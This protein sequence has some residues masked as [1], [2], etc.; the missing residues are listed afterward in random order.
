MNGRWLKWCS[1]LLALCMVVNMLPMS[2][3]AAELTTEE[4]IIVPNF[5]EPIQIEPVQS[6]PVLEAEEILERRTEYTKDFQLNNGLYMTVVYPDAVHYETENGWTEI[7]NTLVVRN[8]AYKNTAGQ[9]EVS[10]PQQ[11]TA[12][13]NISITK[14]GYTLSFNMEGQ[15]RS[16][17]LE[18]A[19]TKAVDSNTFSLSAVKTAV[20]TP[21]QVG[22]SK[23]RE[24]AGFEDT[25]LEKLQSRIQ[26]ANVFENTDILYDLDSNKVKESIIIEKYDDALQGYRYN[27]NTGGMIPVLEESGQILLYDAQQ[28]NVVMVM[29]APFL[30][31][32]NNQYNE[33]IQVQLTGTGSQ[34]TL[35]YLLPKQW[36][37]AAD[38][39]WPV[40]LDPIVKA[41]LSVSNIR[42]RTVAEKKSYDYTWG[43]NTCGYDTDTGIMRFYL[44]YNDLPALSASNVIVNAEIHMYKYGSS[45]TT[46]PVSVHKVTDTWES[47]TLTWSNRPAF[48]STVEDYALVDAADWYHWDVTDIARGWYAEENTGMMFKASAEIETGG[49]AS[50]KQFFSSDYGIE[51]SRP[52]LTITYRH[53]SGIE[54]YYTYQTMGAGHAGTA[55]VADATGLLTVAKGIASYASTVNP[56]AVSLVHNA[57]QIAGTRHKIAMD[58]G[59]GFTMDVIESVEKSDTKKE[60]QL[61]EYYVLHD[62]DGTDHY[63]WDPDND[64]KYTDEDGLGLTMTVH[65]ANYVIA[66]DRGNKRSFTNGLLSSH[67]DENENKIIIDW[68][69]SGNQRYFHN[70]YQKN[71]NGS[72]VTLVTLTYLSG[73]NY[74]E[75]LTDAAGRVYTFHYT[76]NKLTAISLDGTQIATYQY[77]GDRIII[78]QDMESDY[79]LRFEYTDGRVSSIQE[80]IGDDASGARIDVTYYND[81]TK[82]QDY[83]TDRIKDTDDDLF[84]EYSFDDWG[85]TVNACAKDA[86]GKVVGATAQRFSGSGSQTDNLRQNNRV[87]QTASIGVAAQNLLKNHSFESGSSG[88]ILAGAGNGATLEA[89]VHTSHTGT[90]SLEGYIPDGQ[91][92]TL[93]AYCNVMLSAG[94]TYTL[95][96]YV[97]TSWIDSFGDGGVRVVAHNSTYGTWH[98]E[99]VNYKTSDIQ[100]G[101][102]RISRTFTPQTSAVYSLMIQGFGLSGWFY[103]DDVQLEVGE[104]PSGYN[105]IENGSLELGQ[106]GWSFQQGSGYGTE[107]P[108]DSNN[109]L[110]SMAGGPE[111]VTCAWQNVQVN[112]PGTQTYVLSGWAWAD[113]VPDDDS[114][115][116]NEN[117]AGDTTKS[118]GLRATV[119]YTDGSE[120]EFHYVPFSP[121]V[122]AWQFASVTVVPKEPAKTVSYIQVVCA[123][124]RNANTAWF[125]NISLV[126]EAA[127]TMRYDGD[128]NLVGVTT[129]DMTDQTATY[130]NGNL[131]TAQTGGTGTYGYTY[132]S[133]VEHR[134]TAVTDDALKQSYSYDQY[135]NVTGTTLTQKDGTGTSLSTTAQYD[136]SGNRLYYVVD[137]NGNK[138][139]YYYETDMSQMTGTPTKVSTAL[140]GKD[141]E[142]TSSQWLDT[143]NTYDSMGRLTEV[144]IAEK[145]NHTTVANPANVQYTYDNGNLISILRTASG[146]TQTYTLGYDLW[147]NTT[148]VAV[149]DR[150]LATYVYGANNGPLQTMTYGNG[151]TVEYTYD[152]LG[153][154]KQV[155]YKTAS[156]DISRVLSYTYTGDGQLYSIHDSATGKTTVYTY[157]T[158]GR[159]I[160][161]QSGDVRAKSTYNRYNQLTKW[162]YQSV[163]SSTDE[164]YTYDTATDNAISDGTLTGMEMVSGH[165]VGYTYDALQRL[166]Y[167]E[168]NSGKTSGGVWEGFTYDGTRVTRKKNWTDDTTL[169]GDRSYTYDAIGNILTETDNCT[170]ATVTYSYDSLNQLTAVVHTNSA[171]I[172]TGTETYTYDN[173]GNVLTFNNGSDSHTLTYG[174]VQWKDLLTKV[175]GNAITY[176]SIGNPLTYYNGYTFTWAEGRRMQSV[177]TGQNQTTGYEYNADGLRTNKT[178][179]DGSYIEYYIADGRY[180]GEI[181]RTE[182]NEIALYIRYVYDESGS[183]VGISLWD[184]DDT[185]WTEYYFVKNLQGDVL[186]VYSADDE[187]LVTSYTYDAWGNILTKSGTLADINPFRYRSYY[188]DNE[189][190]FYYL[191][192]RYYNPEIGRFINADGYVSTRQSII[193]SNMISYC[194]NNPVVLEDSQGTRPIASTSV[195][196]ETTED[197]KISCEYMR[198]LAIEK[199]AEE[200][201]IRN[202]IFVIALTV[203]GEVGGRYQVSDWKSGMRAVATVI[204]NRKHS[205]LEYFP[206]DFIEVCTCG[207]FDGYS[208]AKK[209]YNNGECDA[210]MWDYAN[211]V[212]TELV[213]N[214]S[215][216]HPLLSFQYTYLHSATVGNQE[217]INGIK[218]KP[219]TVLVGGNLFYINYP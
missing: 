154:T 8:G 111:K 136:S 200:I 43:M 187:T 67:E 29:P 16:S 146:A 92:N 205:P 34:F 217:T 115:A 57:D 9:W 15:L 158:L 54:P 74:I 180:I 194:E 95:S 218:Q 76:G 20:A 47:E 73:T 53:N 39:A 100:G 45:S 116:T 210:I 10:L 59:H 65:G 181:H 189:T 149:A 204:S 1:F 184:S 120:D 203:Y 206:D 55:Y 161:S 137:A 159:P 122:D 107:H 31:D 197:R 150:T 178:N 61:Y 151:D 19:S 84:A 202:Q 50:Y 160:F 123:Y 106:S 13:A 90:K 40:V 145:Q 138:V 32:A 91:D 86:A 109:D 17:G 11:M 110:I 63:F 12:D 89:D 153:R 193:G 38:R 4:K 22:I 168:L 5:K 101:W 165:T 93:S 64:E 176:D 201:N 173:A 212:A 139:W 192:S 144:S 46:T 141:M 208:R 25:V 66:D 21:Q 166:T 199:H 167:K 121:D 26:Y 190:Q 70:I 97:N 56:F 44:Q 191:Q 71:K 133:T 195:S 188:Y 23:A 219:E 27:L 35:T 156:G 79:R 99:F 60:N 183:V 72:Q 117:Y 62:G 127:Q 169:V 162:A 209:I 135:G 68:K 213:T 163:L 108:Y 36:L 216:T 78:M 164:T 6:E 118:F 80:W 155:T 105:L 33:D 170:G 52:I 186:Q 125:D 215:M 3:F 129:T 182:N 142:A 171:G 82:Y 114:E 96:A 88:W 103:V 134:L 112:A 147:G 185:A 119:R 2:G 124:E 207:E 172:V 14:D 51:A 131:L 104:A 37:A 132:D 42:D 148:S 28:E 87:L 211:K 113:A 175:D 24:S 83:G 126:K 7:D 177:T 58:F 130:E 30:V 75:T 41:D 140:P 152:N 102:T 48:I 128:G 77:S 196:N 94:T 85:R 174:D 69:G 49:T 157:D 214:G 143:E 179:P 81:V 18:T 98:S 198:K